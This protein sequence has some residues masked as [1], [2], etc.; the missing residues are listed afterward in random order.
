MPEN[1]LKTKN[2]SSLSAWEILGG[3]QF[4]PNIPKTNFEY[5]KVVNIGIKKHSVTRLASLMKIPMKDMAALLNIS[6]KTLGRKKESDTFDS[7][8]SSLSIEIAE[9]L[10][11]GFS[12][13]EDADKLSR[14]LQKENKALQGRKPID[15]LNTPTGIKMIN[16]LLGRIEEGVY[17]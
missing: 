4:M 6:Y 1:I 11:K 9:V 14:W 17:T 3:K 2:I 12:V 7:I 13:F 16:R 5:I 15:F 8:S 10:S